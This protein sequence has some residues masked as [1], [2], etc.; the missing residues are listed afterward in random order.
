MNDYTVTS[1]LDSIQIL[2]SLARE[3]TLP[4]SNRIMVRDVIARLQS[5]LI[6]IFEKEG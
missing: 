1:I 5:C 4:R 6:P 3:D 2:E